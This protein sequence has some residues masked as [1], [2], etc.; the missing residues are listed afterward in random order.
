MVAGVDPA[1]V[2]RVLL[3]AVLLCGGRLPGDPE[4]C[5]TEVRRGTSGASRPS[6][7]A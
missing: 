5:R 2:Q 1:A 3:V 7:L 4:I 6:S